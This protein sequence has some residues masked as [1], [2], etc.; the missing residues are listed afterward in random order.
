M[1]AD[2]DEIIW[3][4]KAIASFVGRSERWLRS[5]RKLPQAPP[6]NLDVTG[7]LVSTRTALVIWVATLEPS[8]R[9]RK[10]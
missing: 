4:A 10:F 3:G 8:Q 9:I 6:V 1:A 5:R 7:A 2:T